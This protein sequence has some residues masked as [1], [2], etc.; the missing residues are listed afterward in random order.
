MQESTMEH[1]SRMQT[2]KDSLEA[3]SGNL[4]DREEKSGV[5]KTP[6]RNFPFT[7][8]KAPLCTASCQRP[9]DICHFSIPPI[10][11]LHFIFTFSAFHHPPLKRVD[12]KQPSCSHPIMLNVSRKLSSEQPASIARCL[13]SS[14]APAI[15]IF[16]NRIRIRSQSFR[17]E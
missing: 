16:G 3:G 7:L 17:T 9:C 1:S 11:L 5:G 10:R 8:K 12:A 4:Q 14:C 6:I 2:S 13:L 15:C